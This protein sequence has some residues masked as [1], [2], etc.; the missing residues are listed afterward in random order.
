MVADEGTRVLLV[1]DHPVVRH[2]IRAVLEA[3]PGFEVVGMAGSAEEAV[4]QI[5]E[6]S[7][8]AVLLDVS[9]PDLEGAEAVRAVLEACP[10]TAVVMLTVH[11][12][13]RL[14]AETVEAGAVG[15]IIK[16]CSSE[17][18]PLALRAAGLGACL[19]PKK[20][21]RAFATRSL[22]SG[23]P[24]ATSLTM[25]ELDVLR[26]I[27]RG[28]SNRAIS[29]ELRLAESTIKKYVHRLMG[30][31][32]ARDRAHAAIIAMRSGWLE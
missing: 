13:D 4:R 15:Y 20:A 11:E 19:L 16:G 12:D 26:L 31:L 24:E 5:R 30:K 27:S 1:D 32:R 28:Y 8:D 22:R 3:V 29:D 9:L 21:A 14:I 17:L 18:I 7:P 10:Q 2:G 6:S 23:S 25:R